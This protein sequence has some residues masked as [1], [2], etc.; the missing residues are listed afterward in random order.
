MIFYYNILLCGQFVRY[1]EIELLFNFE[2]RLICVYLTKLV[3]T[4]LAYFY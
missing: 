2:N 3:D 4:V 1:R